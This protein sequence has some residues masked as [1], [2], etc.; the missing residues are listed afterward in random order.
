MLKIEATSSGNVEG[1]GNCCSESADNRAHGY[2]EHHDM[3]V[4]LQVARIMI[5][6]WGLANRENQLDND[7]LRNRE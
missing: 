6:D 3:G 2:S 1:D 5:L 4:R 7:M